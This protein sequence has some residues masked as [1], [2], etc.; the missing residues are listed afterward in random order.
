M[1][2]NRNSLTEKN[3]YQT[4]RFAMVVAIALTMFG[5][6]KENAPDCFQSAGE[7]TTVKRNIDSFDILE[8][9]DYVQIELY[10]TSTF[11]VEITAPRNLISDISTEVRD[12]KL[13]IENRN[14]CNFVR[15]F[16]NRVHVRI[17]A[18]RF[19][20]I[21]NYSTG[22]V[23]CVNV[24][25]DPIF[26]IE[27]RNAAG[28]IDLHIDADTATVATHTGVCDVKVRGTSLITNLFNQ[29]LGTVDARELI[30]TDAF[31]NN[32]SI[33]DVFV[34]CNGY[35]FAY[36]A[37]SGNVYYNGNPNY[38]DRDIQGDGKLIAIN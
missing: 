17:Y 33:N 5:C 16:K 32:S 19:S 9:R 27:N 37:F 25:S 22:N 38:I 2:H 28:T 23:S 24:I 6:N 36:I 12:N 18:P 21:Q 1:K 34:N 3:K 26:K 10:D 8:L 13:K 29:G 7:V 14:T 35:F 20:N 31:V 30:T 4:V 15:S 11:F